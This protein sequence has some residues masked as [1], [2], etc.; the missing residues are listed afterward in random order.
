[1][2]KSRLY[3]FSKEYIQDVLD[4]ST[5]Y[6]LVLKELGIQGGSSV[7]TLKKIIKDYNL[8][9]SKM[10]SNRELAYLN[11]YK[12]PGKP[13]WDLNDILIKNSNYSNMN[14]LKKRLFDSG[15][16]QKRCEKCGIVKWLGKDITFQIHHIN[17]VHNDNRIENIQILCPNCHSQTD[18][19]AGA[20]NKK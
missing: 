16:K 15:I 20:N 8:D 19:Y 1:M 12:R 5:G 6:T 13:I 3:N 17:G 9:V 10:L 7:N 4:K 2:K 11:N 18:N 14:S